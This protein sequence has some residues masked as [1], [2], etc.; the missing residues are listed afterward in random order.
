MEKPRVRPIEAIPIEQEGQR[1]V[2]LRDPEDLFSD[3]LVMPMPAFA[4]TTL[5]DGTRDAQEAQQAIMSQTRQMVP[6]DQ[7]EG[8]LEQLDAA[9]LLENDRAQRRREEVQAAFAELASRPAAHAGGAYPEDPGELITAMDGYF[10]GARGPEP[11]RP[12]PERTPR[13]LVTPHIDIRQGGTCLAWGFHE[14]RGPEPPE[15]YIILGVAHCA[16]PNLY[17]LT[18]KDFETPLGPA[19]VHGGA[20]ARLRELYGAERLA[21]EYAHKNEHSVEFQ[22]VFL[23]YLHRDDHPFRIVPLLCGSFG[24]EMGGP[25][26]P[27]RDLAAIGDFIGALET[28]IKEFG[29]RV[30]VIAGVDLS[31]VGLKF[32]DAEPVDDLKAG[33]VEAADRRM[34][35]AAEARD[36]EAFYDHFREDGNARNVD[37]VSAVYTM[38][39]ALG[40]GEANLLRY[41]QYREH[42]THSLVSYASMALY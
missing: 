30:C 15:L 9:Y 38:L 16:T 34:L 29:P 28:L 6:L 32:G 1:M 14:L 17:T 33:L 42:E 36:A 4:I 2:V 22:A 23:K 8:L 20:V 18:G 35:A 37:A 3:P 27:P 26:G 25:E 39:H 41:E 5:F 7:I 19:R 11:A 40:P 13:G 12:I 31:H 10:K 24:E 21:G